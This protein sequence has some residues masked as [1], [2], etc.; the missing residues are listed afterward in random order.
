[1]FCAWL[2]VACRGDIGGH[3]TAGG[4]TAG[5]S[6]NQAGATTGGESTSSGGAGNGTSDGGKATS[7]GTSS[8][9][10][11]SSS[12]SS[13]STGGTGSSGGTPGTATWQ[14][15]SSAPVHFFW[16]INDFSTAH[17]ELPASG[18]VV[19]DL[20]GENTSAPTVA[21]L[22]ALSSSG[23]HVYVFCYVDVGSLELDRSDTAQIQALGADA[24]GKK[25]DGWDEYWLNTDINTAG[26]AAVLGIMEARI[27]T[28]CADKGFDG[29][30]PDNV[31][32]AWNDT[33]FPLTEDSSVGYLLALANYTHSLTNNNGDVM[34][35]GFLKNIIADAPIDS[36][37]YQQRETGRCFRLGPR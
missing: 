21:A 18:E 13:S 31:D 14:P 7:G 24:V 19:Y 26:G 17:D 16:F 23:L 12:S 20:D 3:G 37:G 11:G 15:S 2:F 10:T 9:G 33:N 25:M 32:G 28:W 35:I 30:E 34:S 36:G 5:N 29:I 1:M 8:G 6:V 27:Q 4:S 22:H